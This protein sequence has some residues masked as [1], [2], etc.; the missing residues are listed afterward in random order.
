M[1]RLRMIACGLGMRGAQP[2]MQSAAQA[3][4][5]ACGVWP[6]PRHAGAA[7][8]HAH[9]RAGSVPGYPDPWWIG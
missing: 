7:Q 6:R 4:A 9:A 3:Q 1:V 2:S 8:A 5:H